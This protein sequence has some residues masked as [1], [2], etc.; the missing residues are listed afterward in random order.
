MR[1]IHLLA[2][3]YTILII[4][5]LLYNILNIINPLNQPPK[6]LQNIFHYSLHAET[7][8]QVKVHISIL[9]C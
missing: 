2:C 6:T 3:L 4:L 8:F 5:H 7:I 9:L 1:R